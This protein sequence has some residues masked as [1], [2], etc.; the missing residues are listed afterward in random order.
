M[1]KTELMILK[2]GEREI[3]R[4]FCDLKGTKETGEKGGWR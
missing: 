2:E 3:N 4:H 1:V